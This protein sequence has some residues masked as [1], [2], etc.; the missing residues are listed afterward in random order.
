MAHFCPQCGAPTE[1]DD[2]FCKAC[3]TKLDE[4][5]DDKNLSKK[6][7]QK[8]T[9]AKTAGKWL[10]L[11][12]EGVLS[13]E[14]LK[15]LS[16]LRARLSVKRSAQ[17]SLDETVRVLLE[18]ERRKREVASW[19]YTCAIFVVV[20]FLLLWPVYR[21]APQLVPVIWLLGVIVAAVSTYFLTTIALRQHGFLVAGQVP[22]E[23]RSS[24]ESMSRTVGMR[25]IPRVCV[26]NTEELNALAF[27]TIGSGGICLTRGLVS[28]Y[29]EG[30]LTLEE[31]NAI[32]GHELGHLK[33]RDCFRFGLAMSWVNIFHWLGTLCTQLG[34]A[35]L[36][37]THQKEEEEEGGASLV[38]TLLSIGSVC[39]GIIMVLL[40]KLVSALS[41]HLSRK[42]ELEADDIGAELTHPRIMAQ[43]LSKIENLNQEL[44]ER[45]IAQ[46][47]Y[48]DRWQLRPR[49]TSW[50]DRLWDTHP[51]T[52][53]RMG[54]LE[55]LVP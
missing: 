38:I 22:E 14:T 45:K 54:R 53:N 13:E 5:V 7:K 50:V 3:G 9:M 43:A 40:S 8:R 26:Y 23:I 52:K 35:V 28:A 37:G 44:V 33:H 17:L 24:I 11:E 25:K 34:A 55:S 36:A 18:K 46:L 15:R 10:D 1:S 21:A 39:A 49:N 4:I 27:E 2:K 47:P 51:S 42:Q 31:F 20:T 30:K 19:L 12:H 29:E 32:I 48:A 16:V 6:S 41:F